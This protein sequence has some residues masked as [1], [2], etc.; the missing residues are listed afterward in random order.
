MSIRMRR[1]ETVRLEISQGDWLLVKKHLTAGEQRA[2]FARMMS[3]S[4]NGEERRIDRLQVGVAKIL[5][6][7]LDWSIQ[8]S[9][10]NQVVIADQPADVIAS[11]ID[12]LDTD[13]YAEI[14]DAIN[15]HEAAMDAELGKEKNAKDGGK[16]SS[17]TLPSAARSAGVMKTSKNSQPTSTAS[18]LTN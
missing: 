15:A 11:A 3:D 2:M 8:D 4:A 1:P 13:S 5:A 18:S 14:K 7:L 17:A 9:E 16:G 6:Y 12:N 10:G